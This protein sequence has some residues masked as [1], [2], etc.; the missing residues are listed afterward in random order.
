MSTLSVLKFNSPDS[1]NQG[2]TELFGEHRA[3]P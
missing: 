2:L 1:A 3:A